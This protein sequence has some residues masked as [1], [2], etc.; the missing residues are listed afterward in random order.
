MPSTT[1]VGM[2]YQST[3]LNES[4]DLILKRDFDNKF[5]ENAVGVYQNDKLV[6]H[7]VRGGTH[8]F[9]EGV[10][11][12]R[13]LS[14]FPAS[15]IIYAVSKEPT[16]DDKREIALILLGFALYNNYAAQ[17]LGEDLLSVYSF[18]KNRINVNYHDL[19]TF[20]GLD[21]LKK[22]EKYKPLI[23]IIES[24]IIEVAGFNQLPEVEIDPEDLE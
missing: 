21:N 11:T 6:A 9:K 7:V 18:I 24:E 12:A 1:I 20:N 13:I 14:K 10:F 16:D 17:L 4:Q 23:K 2:K 8:M 19:G 15:Y 22:F 3:K 5:D